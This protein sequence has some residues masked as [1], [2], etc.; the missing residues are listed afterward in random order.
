MKIKIELSI[1]IKLLNKYIKYK[2]HEN[3]FSFINGI[4]ILR[5][6]NKLYKLNNWTNAE[7]YRLV[8]DFL[9][10]LKSIKVIK[11]GAYILNKNQIYL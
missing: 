10:K 11:T 3:N 8:S 9:K 4:N 2:N 7:E 1:L 6:Y 5:E